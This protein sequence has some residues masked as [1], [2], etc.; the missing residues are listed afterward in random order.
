MACQISSWKELKLKL[1]TEHAPLTISETDHSYTIICSSSVADGVLECIQN[2]FK[3]NALREEFVAAATVGMATVVDKY[4]KNEITAVC[5]DFVA[6]SVTVNVVV[7]DVSRG[8]G[9]VVRG[10]VHGL[11][12]AVKR[13]QVLLAKV[14]EREKTIDRPGILQYLQS[15]RGQQ[16]IESIEA[17]RRACI[18]EVAENAAGKPVAITAGAGPAGKLTISVGK[19]FTMKIVVGDIT[20]YKVDAVVN[21]ANRSLDHAGGV[22][23]SIVDKGMTVC[24]LCLISVIIVIAAAAA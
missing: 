4:L 11:K 8:T 21:A 13:M 2:F 15:A 20:E 1:T 17:K 12:N 7:D 23:R 19:K 6:C 5:S 3:E 16:T 18:E 24:Q 9:F 14:I 22:A 10:T